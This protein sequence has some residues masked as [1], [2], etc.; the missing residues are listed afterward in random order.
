ME[1][2]LK[3][4]LDVILSDFAQR[5]IDEYRTRLTNEDAIASKRLYSDLDYKIKVKSDKADVRLQ[6]WDYWKYVD[7]GR[8]KGEDRQGNKWMKRPPVD[9]IEKWLKYKKPGIQVKDRHGLAFYIAKKINQNGIKPKYLLE[10]TVHKVWEQYRK[11]IDDTI[12]NEVY[13]YIIDVFDL[14]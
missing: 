5:V 1:G 12:S 10:D 7:Y 2:L 13:G 3:E 8:Q 14:N 11:E 9:A 4:K 6:L